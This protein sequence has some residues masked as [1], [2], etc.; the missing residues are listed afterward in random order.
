MCGLSRCGPTMVG[1][2]HAYG[3]GGVEVLALRLDGREGVVELLGSVAD[4]EREIAGVGENGAGLTQTHLTKSVGFR[5]FSLFPAS[6]FVRFRVEER[7]A[8]RL[9]ALRDTAPVAPRFDEGA[10]GVVIFEV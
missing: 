6:R 7:E 2:A 8:H 5:R 9:L 10:H 1:P 4:G 3:L